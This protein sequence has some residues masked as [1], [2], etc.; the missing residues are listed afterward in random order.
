[1]NILDLFSGAGGF[2]LGFEQAG[3]LTKYAVE[4]DKFA[5]ETFSNNFKDTKTFHKLELFIG[6]HLDVELNTLYGPL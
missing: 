2:S 3:L 5:V 6:C 1:M 4:K